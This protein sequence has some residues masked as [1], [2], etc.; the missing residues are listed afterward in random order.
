MD[1]EQKERI[2][3]MTMCIH[4]HLSQCHARGHYLFSLHCKGNNTDKNKKKFVLAIEKEYKHY[5]SDFIDFIYYHRDIILNDNRYNFSFKNIAELINKYDNLSQNGINYHSNTL[6]AMSNILNF[7]M[8][9]LMGVD[10]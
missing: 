4:F 6:L 10:L 9:N 3:Y 7:Y 1:K 8:S 5:S 2:K